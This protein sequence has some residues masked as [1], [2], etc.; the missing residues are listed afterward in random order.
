MRRYYVV[1]KFIIGGW[2]AVK[3]ITSLFQDMVLLHHEVLIDFPEGRPTEN[4]EAT[5][6]EFGRTHNGKEISAMALTVGIPVAIGALVSTIL[7][8]LFHFLSHDVLQERVW[9]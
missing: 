2:Y 9:C 6:L 7:L 8:S 1:Q 4:H 3:I 5:L